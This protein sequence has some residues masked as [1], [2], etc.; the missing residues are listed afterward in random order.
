MG[1]GPIP[2]PPPV[3]RAKTQ[4][5]PSALLA[6]A[7]HMREVTHHAAQVLAVYVREKTRLD[8]CIGCVLKCGSGGPGNFFYRAVAIQGDDWNVGRVFL[9]G[10]ASSAA[11]MDRW[12]GLS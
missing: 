12:R 4:K 3:P 6:V 11:A 9:A 5:P 10:S 1:E 8:W 7:H 2:A